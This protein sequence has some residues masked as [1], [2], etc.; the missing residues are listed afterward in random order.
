MNYIRILCLL[1]TLLLPAVAG[2]ALAAEPVIVVIKKMK[3]QPQEV[4]V[5]KG[6]MVRWENREKR[7][8]H[9][10]WF[11]KQGEPEPDYFFPEESYERRFNST[12]V[13]P[14]RCGPHEEMTGLVR[15]L[16]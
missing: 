11:E 12:G 6:A 4:T 8:Y 16:D 3:F 2:N 1:P 5:K 15:V 13:F 9:S 7:Q 10:V 14:Y